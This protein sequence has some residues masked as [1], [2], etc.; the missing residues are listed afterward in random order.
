M[1]IVVHFLGLLELYKQGLVELEQTTT[2][3]ELR[4]C[5]TGGLSRREQPDEADRAVCDSARVS[6]SRCRFGELDYSG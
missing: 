3:G 5:W 2:F 1:E 4:V 6:R